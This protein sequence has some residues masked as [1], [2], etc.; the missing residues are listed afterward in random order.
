MSKPM[1]IKV[2]EVEYIRKDAIPAAPKAGPESIV[3]TY[4]AGVHIG[5]VKSLEGMTVRLANARRLWRWEGA[6]SLNEV[7]TKGVKR[8][9]SRISCAVPLITLTQAIEIIPVAEGVD[10]STTE[11]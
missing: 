1:T 11:K 2:D 4:S 6:F 5:E 9:G 3:R 7:A 8:G 10:L